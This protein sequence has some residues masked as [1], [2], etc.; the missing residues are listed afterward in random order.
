LARIHARAANVRADALHKA[1]TDLARRYETIVCEDLNV[2]GLLANTRLARAI[3]DQ[4]FGTARRMLAYKT[5]WH[6]GRLVVADRWYPSSKTCSGCG[7]V[8]TKLPLSE[9][10]YRC[11]HCGLTLGRDVNAARNLLNL[12]ATGR[13]GQNARGAWVRPVLDGRQAMNQEPGTDDAGQ[14]G[15][16]VRQRTAAA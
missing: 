12:A 2:A 10:S 14:T 16:A 3:S 5:T 4:G 15:T 8:K 6:G 11:D 13:R 9:R 1:T 7:T